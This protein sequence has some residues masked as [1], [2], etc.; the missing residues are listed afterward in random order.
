M[1]GGGAMGTSAARWLAERGRRTL[2]LERFRIGHANGSSH[3][4]NRIFRLAYHH[5]DYVR[6]AKLALEEWRALED[7][8]GEPLL[9]TT[10]GLDA[11]PGAPVAAEALRTAGGGFDWLDAD[12]A[13]ERW[14]LLRPPGGPLL[15]QAD[16]GV[17]R[18]D[19][20]VAAQARLA[21]AAGADVR[22]ETP[23]ER[24]AAAGDGA[25]VTTAAG[26]VHRAPVVVVT[27]GAWAQ[28]LLA[29]AG[30]D[31]PLRVTGEVIG[32]ARLPGASPLPTLIEWPD[33]DRPHARYALPVPGRPDLVKL[34]AHQAGTVVDPDPAR[35]PAVPADDA[36]ALDAFAE[37]TVPRL[38]GRGRRA[39]PV[40][41]HRRR[42]LRAGPGRAGGDRVALQ[43]ARV[44]V[45]AADRADPGRSGHGARSAGAARAVRAGSNGASPGPAVGWCRTV[46]TTPS[47]PTTT[48]ARC[49]RPVEP[50]EHLCAQCR[51]EV[52][53]AAA[54]APPAARVAREQRE[55]RDS[56]S[57][58]PSAPEPETRTT[59]NAAAAGG[60]TRWSAR[61]RSSTT[62][63][64]SSRSCSCSP[65]S[66]VWAWLGH[67]GVGP[68]DA[69]VQSA[70]R[71]RA[72]TQTIVV[73]VENKG[74]RSSRATCTFRALDAIRDASSRPRRS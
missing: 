52:G 47:T 11:G 26:D 22:E 71:F 59:S 46:P 53:P 30:I 40:H 13:R 28:P 27:A 23:V 49:G 19:A 64:S 39:L 16:A 41:E 9:D 48:C 70:G 43:R 74:S 61:A 18:A 35:R 33:G 36:A 5:P 45:H 10:G 60:R 24:I 4:P 25:E 20:T 1:V 17:C 55:P 14:P 72:G 57:R 3:G 56:P 42:G 38:V 21:T 34:G 31:V 73:A 69:N 65:G 29:T 50:G 62:P 2:L 15:F 12:A 6:M 32:Y 44:Q 51:E 54:A 63:R 58:T 68:F 37:R 7:A 67:R 8:A 66:A